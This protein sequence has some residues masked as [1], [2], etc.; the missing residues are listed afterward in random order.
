MP[1]Q[2]FESTPVTENTDPHWLSRL[3]DHIE[4]RASPARPANAARPR[5]SPTVKRSPPMS[6]SPFITVA[7]MCCHIWRG[8]KVTPCSLNTVMS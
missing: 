2:V 3:I 7:P 6:F 1:L 4:T 5:A 8:L